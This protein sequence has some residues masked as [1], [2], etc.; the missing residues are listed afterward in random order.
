MSA[1]SFLFNLQLP[2]L[3]SSYLS[4]SPT[5]SIS[6]LTFSSA[7]LFQ[8][9]PV[10]SWACFPTLWARFLRKSFPPSPP[11]TVSHIFVSSIQ[12]SS[13]PHANPF[14]SLQDFSRSKS[15]HYF[16]SPSPDLFLS[17]SACFQ[18]MALL[19]TQLFKPETW[20]SF[21][22]STFWLCDLG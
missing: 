6:F 13:D 10:L 2:R 8:S 12:F 11:A 7:N 9:W 16:Y 17:L 4:A 22:V 5:W 21:S 19:F 14:T 15:N 3:L 1:T 20:K 18:P